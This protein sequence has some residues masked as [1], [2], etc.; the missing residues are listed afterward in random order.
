MPCFR[1]S[2]SVTE[3]DLLE[4]SPF[5]LA[6]PH[7]GKSKVRLYLESQVKAL[8][9]RRERERKIIAER[10]REREEQE[11]REKERGEPEVAAKQGGSKAGEREGEEGEEGHRSGDSTCDE[12]A[13]SQ[14]K[15]R[16]R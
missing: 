13:A 4:L 15:R 16:R 3:R 11:A 12:P 6:N 14:A 5:E 1:S 8:S 9:E 2:F 7:G 10:E